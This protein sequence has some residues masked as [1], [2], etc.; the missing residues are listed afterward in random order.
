MS[1]EKSK[2]EDVFI[3]N[4]FDKDAL[5]LIDEITN[6]VLSKGKFEV[7]ENAV[8]TKKAYILAKR[9]LFAY[10]SKISSELESK[11]RIVDEIIVKEN[12]NEFIIYLL[13]PGIFILVLG[14]AMYFLIG[15]ILWTICCAMI[16]IGFVLL[17]LERLKKANNQLKNKPIEF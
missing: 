2:H 12:K 10:N 15:S 14:I 9:T 13:A 4:P 7:G 16:T 5:I 6:V 1:F 17:G 11:I 8:C 3:T